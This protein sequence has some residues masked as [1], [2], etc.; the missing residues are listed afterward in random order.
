MQVTQEVLVISGP[1]EDDGEDVVNGETVVVERTWDGGM[2]NIQTSS[3]TADPTAFP[4]LSPN[5]NSGCL[6]YLIAISGRCFPIGGVIPI[7]LTLLP[8]DKVRI[9]RLGVTLE[10]EF[11]VVF[12]LKLFTDMSSRKSRVS[13]P[14]Q[15]CRTYGSCVGDASVVHQRRQRSV[16]REGKGIQTYPSPRF[17]RPR[18]TKKES[19]MGCDPEKCFEQDERVRNCSGGGGRV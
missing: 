1:G 16:E 3:A 13:R 14:I 5:L 9:H 11:F 6:Q 8:L 10:R 15:T 18:C 2:P 12:L 7:E 19:F 17:R 4:M